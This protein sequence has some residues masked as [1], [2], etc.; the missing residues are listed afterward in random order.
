MTLKINFLN[1]NLFRVYILR[2]EENIK[3]I[4]PRY[5]HTALN[6]IKMAIFISLYLS[7][8]LVNILI[9]ANFPKAQLCRIY[10]MRSI[11][12]AKS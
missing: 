9:I 7:I 5:R 11:H 4:S 3:K 10:K 6:P 12:C 2:R 8:F 1:N